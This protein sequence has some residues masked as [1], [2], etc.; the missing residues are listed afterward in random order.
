MKTIRFVPASVR[1]LLALTTML[2]T[3][4]LSNAQTTNWFAY[5]NY[6]SGPIVP[7]HVP[8]PNSWGTAPNVTTIDM[9]DPGG[10]A[11]LLTDFRTG[12]PLP[13]TLTVARTGTADSFGALG[14]P[15]PTNTPMARLF[16]GICDLSADG[17][18]GVRTNAT[19]HK[20]VTLTF[21]GLNPAKRYVFRGTTA[22]NGGYG[23]R[24]S[25][26]AISAD[27]W[28]DAH[29]NGAGG[30]GVITANNFPAAGLVA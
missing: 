16:L 28:T 12:N 11:G 22:R 27:G 13:V 24:W 25:Q 15:M 10:T 18:V 26:A 21:S 4:I 6:R 17:L 14:R 20:F 29:I 2:V 8:T 3:T 23:T 7:P 1:C 19:D 9:G 30:P 5:N